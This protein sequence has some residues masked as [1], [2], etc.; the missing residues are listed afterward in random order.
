[1]AERWHS[2]DDVA[3]HLGVVPDTIYWWLV[4]GRLPAHRIERQLHVAC[5][6]ARDMPLVTS[7]KPSSEF[8]DYLVNASQR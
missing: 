3:E 4:A 1:M 5:T 2:V 8:L 6:R 7:A